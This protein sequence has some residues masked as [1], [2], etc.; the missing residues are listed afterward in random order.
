MTRSTRTP[1]PR[2]L[3]GL[4]FAA[5]LALLVA[6]LVQALPADSSTV[7]V[8]APWQALQDWVASVFGASEAGP[9]MD[10]NG[11]SADAGPEMDPDGNTADAG[12]DMDPNGLTAG[13]D[14]GP[15]MDPNG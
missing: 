6:P 13:G 10:P 12:P 4:A 8:W 15:D 1:R 7:S 14:A 9:D 2:R 5:A 11:A 3:A